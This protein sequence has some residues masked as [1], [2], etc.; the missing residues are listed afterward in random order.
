[1]P[2]YLF[3]PE[4]CTWEEIERPQTKLATIYGLE[5]SFYSPKTRIC[6]RNIETGET[7]IFTRELDSNGNLIRFIEH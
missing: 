6:I 3:M 2:K 5:C 4:G 7:A 1:M